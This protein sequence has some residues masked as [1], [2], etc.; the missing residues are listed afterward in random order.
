MK[1][2][3]PDA[4]TIMQKVV[5]IRGNR[6]DSSIP[7]GSAQELRNAHYRFQPVWQPTMDV[8]SALMNKLFINVSLDQPIPVT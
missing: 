3:Q 4:K 1:R 6:K 5:N 7:N 8:L 2:I